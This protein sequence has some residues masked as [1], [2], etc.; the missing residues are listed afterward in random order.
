MEVCDNMEIVIIGGFLGGGKTTVLNHLIQEALNNGKKPA[1]LMNE[2]GEKSVDSYLINRNIQVNEIVNGCICCELKTDVTKQLHEIYMTFKPDIVFIEC[3]GIAHPSEVLDACLTPVLAP[4]SKVISILGVLDAHLYYNLEKL[5]KRIQK[6]VD[7]QLQHCSNILLNKVDLLNS[8]KILEILNVLMRKYP[9]IKCF[10]TKYGDIKIE[11]ITIAEEEKWI[12]KSDDQIFHGSIGHCLYQFS[13]N[14]HK[15][16]F[17][18]WIQNLPSYV[19]RVKG[20]IDFGENGLK[21]QI[22]YANNQ[23]NIQTTDLN[24]DNYIVIIGHNINNDEIIRSIK[25]SKKDI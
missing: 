10:I 9:K 21:S 14:W 11:N 5:P 12:K 22:Q 13:S 8:E 6:L 4:F 2:F 1:V 19:Y 23:L 7:V 24:V 17:I 25:Q 15:N 3:S 18:H 20:F 16:D